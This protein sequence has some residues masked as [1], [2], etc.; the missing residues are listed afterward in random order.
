MLRVTSPE[1]AGCGPPAFGLASLAATS[2]LRPSAHP[3]AAALAGVSFDLR[4]KP[5]LLFGLSRLTSLWAP[6]KPVWPPPSFAAAANYGFAEAEYHDFDFDLTWIVKTSLCQH[7][8]FQ[9]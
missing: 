5:G 9:E 2:V 1:W 4:R 7:L 8:F 6:R 3:G